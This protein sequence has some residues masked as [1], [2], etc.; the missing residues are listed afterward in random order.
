MFFFFFILMGFSLCDMK[1]DIEVDL[2]G[3]WRIKHLK[4]NVMK[5]NLPILLKYYLVRISGL[6]RV[7]ALVMQH[8]ENGLTDS[9]SNFNGA[10]FCDSN[11][12]H[13]K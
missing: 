8:L 4:S 7:I 3:P 10:F 11:L 2:F 6:A 13:F 9:H 12:Q 5:A 1:S